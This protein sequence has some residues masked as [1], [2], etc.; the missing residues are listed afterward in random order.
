MYGTHL[1]YFFRSIRSWWRCCS[2]L[3]ERK[4]Y[5]EGYTWT[6]STYIVNSY[7]QL[8]QTVADTFTHIAHRNFPIHMV[9]FAQT[10]IFRYCIFIYLCISQY[11]ILFSSHGD[12]YTVFVLFSF[13]PLF[14]NYSL[15][16]SLILLHKIL[17]YRNVKLLSRFYLSNERDSLRKYK[18]Q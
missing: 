12:R 4:S 5:T 14:E 3:R 13:A 9:R 18:H 7:I 8:A 10:H 17:R 1:F 16:F 15:S 2:H 6:Y 11:S